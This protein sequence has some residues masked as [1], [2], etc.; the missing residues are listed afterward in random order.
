MILLAVTGDG[1][2]AVKVCGRSETVDSERYVQFV[3]NVCE[4]WR[5][6]RSSPTQLPQLTWY[7]ENARPHRAW[8][9]LDFCAIRKVTLLRQSPYS[10]HL[11]LCDRFILRD[12]KEHLRKQNYLDTI[13]V[14]D[15][16]LQWLKSIAQRSLWTKLENCMII[17]MPLF[18]VKKTLLCS[19]IKKFIWF[20]VFWLFSGDS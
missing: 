18:S 19:S 2:V 9:T 12:L 10:I 8:N 4:K 3:H 17:A 1:K 13:E 6:L 5:H 7:F 15:Q 16:T 14:K 11:N 20:V